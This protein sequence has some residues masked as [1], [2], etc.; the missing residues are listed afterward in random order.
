MK[1]LVYI[2]WLD[3]QST[4]DWTG[5]DDIKADELAT[6]HTYGQLIKKTKKSV[7]VA[8]N[9]DVTNNNYSCFIA[10]PLGWI[11]KYKEV[12]I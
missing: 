12:K 10:I 3:A 7:T 2:E 4:D 8:L 11:K 1:K 5:V 9:H 6:I